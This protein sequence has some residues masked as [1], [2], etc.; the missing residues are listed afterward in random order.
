VANY[1]TNNRIFPLNT[2]SNCGEPDWRCRIA[3]SGHWGD[4]EYAKTSYVANEGRWQPS[5]DL[6]PA[7]LSTLATIPVGGH[8][9]VGDCAPRMAHAS[10]C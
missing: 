5:T 3:S 8:P 2:S 6:S 9:S 7:D 10:T 1:G 4:A